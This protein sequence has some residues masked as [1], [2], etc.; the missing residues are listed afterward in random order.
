MK[1]IE[2]RLMVGALVVSIAALGMVSLTRALATSRILTS[3]SLGRIEYNGALAASKLNGWIEN[4]TGYLEA[5]AEDLSWAMES[6]D[7]ETLRQSIESHYQKYDHQFFRLYFG[8]PDGSGWFSNGWQPERDW[9]AYERP[10]YTGA[11]KNQGKIFISQPYRGTANGNSY[12]A[13]SKAVIRNGELAAVAG[14]DIDLNTIR[15]IIDSV[16]IAEGR[17][18]S[19]LVAEDTGII[20]VHP[21]ENLMPSGEGEYLSLYDIPEKAYQD[22][23]KSDDGKSVSITRPGGVR[24][25]Y[26]GH[27]IPS[28]GW[29]LFLSVDQDTI[30]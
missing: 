24:R 3:Q 4:Q 20:L 5:V 25:Y 22:L 9:Q 18:F 16:P 19:F 13:L 10:W 8:Y 26:N 12:I 23:L 29:K 2:F 28:A 7:A 14:A 30:L 27:T 21:E 11:L 1:N 15:R 17:G 6:R